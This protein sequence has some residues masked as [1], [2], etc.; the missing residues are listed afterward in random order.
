MTFID[1]ADIY[2][3]PLGHDGPQR[4]D[5][6]QGGASYGGNTDDVVIATKGGITR[7]EGEELGPRRLA[8]LPA[9]RGGEVAAQRSAST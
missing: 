8:G 7:S 6:R 4:D 9:V 5:R 1:T 2:A 3:P